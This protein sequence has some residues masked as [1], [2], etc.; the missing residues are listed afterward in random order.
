MWIGNTSRSLKICSCT[1]KS[2]ALPPSP[3]TPVSHLPLKALACS[4]CPRLLALLLFL[5]TPVLLLPPGV[6]GSLTAGL[7]QRRERSGSSPHRSGTFSSSAFA[8]SPRLLH[9]SW[10]HRKP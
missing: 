9:I 4:P 5:R 7:S 3:R 2:A 10:D 6:S 1:C 8:A